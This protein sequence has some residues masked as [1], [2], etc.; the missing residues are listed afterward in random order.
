MTPFTAIAM[1]VMH[2]EKKCRLT[3]GEFELAFDTILS[4]LEEA[5]NNKYRLQPDITNEKVENP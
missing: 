5:N 3:E 2:T 4:L 1:L